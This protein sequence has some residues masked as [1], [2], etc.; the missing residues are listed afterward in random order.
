MIRLIAFA[1][2]CVVGYTLSENLEVLTGKNDPA[3]KRVEG[4]QE[5]TEEK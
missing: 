1:L 4:A 3:I 2:G 5:V